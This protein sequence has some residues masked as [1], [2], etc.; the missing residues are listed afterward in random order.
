MEAIKQAQLEKSRSYTAC[1]TEAYKMFFK[2]IR[3]LFRHTWIYTLALAMAIAL[4]SS[5]YINLLADENSM[6]FDPK[7]T[8][9]LIL[10]LCA[11]IAFSAR[12][13][14]L[15]NGQ[16]MRYNII[17]CAKLTFLAITAML[18]FSFIFGG[19]VYFM[20]GATATRPENIN[21]LIFAFMALAT[22]FAFVAL[23]FAYVAMKYLMDT[24][25]R[26]HKIMLKAYKTG[27]RHWGFIFTTCI[28]CL[29][30]T[31]ACA[32]FVSA[33]TIILLTANSIS[34]AGTSLIGDPSGLPSYFG[35]LRFF[36]ITITSFINLYISIFAVLVYYFIY[37]S[38]ETR[39][40]EKTD[41]I[42]QQS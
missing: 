7:I 15:L 34:A 29:I 18:L 26:L 14:M 27:I 6:E 20:G 13:I 23:P 38:I 5:F 8:L 30:I 10:M 35:L 41:F 33:P 28:I 31:S 1:I 17:K 40:K 39:E 25:S 32:V 9:A 16:G 3:L 2:N 11:N 12:V 42:K 36:T 37:G 22:V 19:I 4:Y 24:D 21:M